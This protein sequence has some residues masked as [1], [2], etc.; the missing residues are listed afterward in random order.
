MNNVVPMTTATPV[1]QDWYWDGSKWVCS[2]TPPCAIPPWGPF[3]PP[4]FPPQQ[5]P[6][7]PGANGGVSFSPPDIPPPFPVRGHFWWNGTILQMFDGAVWVDVSN[8]MG[9]TDGSQAAAG[10][11]GEYFQSSTN[12]TFTVAADEHHLVTAGI[13]TAGDWQCT[14]NVSPGAWLKGL[15]FQLSPQ[16]AGFSTTMNGV[17]GDMSAATVSTSLAIVAGTP[18]RALLT[19][20]TTV[21]FDVRTNFLAAG[22][23]GTGSLTFAARRMR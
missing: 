21:V 20:Q 13:L 1:P 2:G 6:W 8:G 4:Y 23:S 3:P 22:G 19:A 9:V 18:A 12:Y 15:A 11:V 16:P 5:P 14:A 10:Q 7:Y 17:A